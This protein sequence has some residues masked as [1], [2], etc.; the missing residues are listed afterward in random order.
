[1][2]TSQE[3]SDE[4]TIRALA[5]ACKMAGAD[6]HHLG[7]SGYSGMALPENLMAYSV[8]LRGRRHAYRRM[9]TSPRR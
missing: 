1:M 4:G 9:A 7:D 3:G 8:A 5:L 2:G 6:L